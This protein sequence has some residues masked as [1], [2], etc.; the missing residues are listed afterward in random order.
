MTRRNGK[1]IHGEA[2]KNSSRDDTALAVKVEEG[3]LTICELYAREHGEPLPIPKE[4]D[5]HL[6]RWRSLRVR[7][8]QGDFRNTESEKLSTRVVA[9]W[10]IDVNR[11]L[12]GQEPMKLQWVD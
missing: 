4:L 10:T 2:L 1:V 5:Q 7:H 12:R 11:K 6:F 9:Q 8:K 3:F